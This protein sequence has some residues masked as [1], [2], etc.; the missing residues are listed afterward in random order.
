MINSNKN[1]EILETIY[2]KLE[3][4]EFGVVISQ[5]SKV[6]EQRL[7]AC[8]NVKQQKRISVLSGMRSL[9]EKIVQYSN[10]KKNVIQLPSIKIME[11]CQGK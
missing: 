3:H 4:A 6:R 11:F 1:K 2:A 8:I 9:R 10:I 5:T 7:N